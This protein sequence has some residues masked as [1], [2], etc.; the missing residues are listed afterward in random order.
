MAGLLALFLAAA[1]A[2]AVP[3]R[4]VDDP[5]RPDAR[6]THGPSCHPGG[7][8]V[9][10]AA[11]TVP[12]TVRLATTRRPAGEDDAVLVARGSAVLRTADVAPGETIDPWLEFTAQDGSGV[13]YVD[14]LAD[15]TLTRPTV[16]DC[17][18]ALSPPPPPPAP[19]T[20]TIEPTAPGS[21]PSTGTRAAPSGTPA[22]VPGTLPGTTPGTAPGGTP[23]TTPAGAGGTAPTSTGS[24]SSRTGEPVGIPMTRAGELAAQVRAGG[25]VTLR[26]AGFI[27]GERVDVVLRGSDAV[28]ASAT[29]DGEGAVRVEVRIPERLA[30]GPA[31]LDLVGA[32]S[33]VSTGVGLQVAAASGPIGTPSGGFALASLIAAAAALLAT[34]AGLVSVVTQQ[35]GGRRDG[36][37]IRTG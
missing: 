8:V 23:T 16:E 18:L 26:G 36:T 37:P 31:T 29:A 15:Y 33:A 34:V 28:L 25:T 17:E 5:T 21:S 4:A 20:A 35:H 13:A 10:V 27:P 11:G 30:S 19:P 3:A 7:I 2:A 22:P 9:E 14:E 12:Y 6:V 32:D 1:V 24:T